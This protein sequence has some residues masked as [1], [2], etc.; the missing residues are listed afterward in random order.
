VDD[1]SVK[2]DWI[3]R[4]SRAKNVFDTLSSNPNF[5]S[6]ALAILKTNLVRMF[7][8]TTASTIGFGDFTK[9][10]FSLHDQHIQHFRANASLWEKQ[11]DGLEASLG[12]FNFFLIPQGTATKAPDG[13]IHVAISRIGVY[14][15]DAFT[16]ADDNNPFGLGYWALPDKVSITK[17]DG[18]EKVDNA[19]YRA[20]QDKTGRGGAFYIF[21]DVRSILL[22]QPLSYRL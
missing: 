9:K 15:H 12:T 17:R 14:A 2:M 10:G 8:E 18:Y 22:K 6:N 19:R 5:N 13:K 1:T 7:S 3:L 16:F 21:S 4:Y 20:Y 11:L